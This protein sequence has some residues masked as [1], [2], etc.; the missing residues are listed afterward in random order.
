MDEIEIHD[1]VELADGT[2]FPCDYLATIPN[3][4][5]FIS[6][7]TENISEILLAFTDKAKTATIYYG[8][9][10]LHNYTV[11]VSITQEAP[12]QFK[13]AMRKAFVDEEE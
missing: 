5:L 7:K 8:D 6:L 11:F 9:H 3:G 10:E 2:V 12:R 4:Y 1:T 13:I